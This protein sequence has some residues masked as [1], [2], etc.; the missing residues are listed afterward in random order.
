MAVTLADAAVAYGANKSEV[1]LTR[2]Y[3]ELS[4]FLE[5]L[6][7]RKITG[8]AFPYSRETTLPAAGW[9]PVNASWSESTGVITRLAENLFILGGEVA[10]DQFIEETDDGADFNNKAVQIQLKAQAIS[11]E[12]DRSVL[13]GDDRVDANGMVGL[14]RRLPAAQIVTAGTTA[15]GTL[16]LALLDQLIDLVPFPNKRLYMNRTE[17][18]KIKTLTDAVGGSIFIDEKRDTFGQQPAYYAGIP[19]RIIETSGSGATMLDFDEDPGNGTPNTAS[20]YCVAMGFD[21]VFGIWNGKKPLA[22]QEFP[23]TPRPVRRAAPTRSCC[24]RPGP[25]RTRTGAGTAGCRPP[26]SSGRSTTTRGRSPP[27]STTRPS[28]GSPTTRTRARRS[29][30]PGPAWTTRS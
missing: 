15:G 18:R 23:P 5:E 1:T 25:N 22:M 6:P 4:P 13:E 12:F 29:R 30:W 2:M 3:M 20:I 8:R 24:G 19:I 11:T 17:R 9:R 28:A 27:T 21:T 7:M 26:P 10:E 14:R 16:T